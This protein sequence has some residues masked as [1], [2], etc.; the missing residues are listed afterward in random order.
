VLEVTPGRSTTKLGTPS[1]TRFR[2]R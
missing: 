2:V 1:R